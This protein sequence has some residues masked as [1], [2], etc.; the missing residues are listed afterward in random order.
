MD[1]MEK[2]KQRA[3]D[4][5]KA[6]VLELLFDETHNHVG[7]PVTPCIYQFQFGDIADKIDKIYHPQACLD[8]AGGGTDH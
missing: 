4:N 7:S 3:R 6:A 2:Y 8:E 1:I 5:R